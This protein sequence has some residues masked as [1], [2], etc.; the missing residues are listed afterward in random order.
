MKWLT[1]EVLFYGGI[2]V[3]ALSIVL[4][5]LYCTISKRK[6]KRLSKQLD[7]EYGTDNEL[8][9]KEGSKLCRR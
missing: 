6:E 4:L 2:I 7:D 9:P 3:A 1:N 8:K 5:I